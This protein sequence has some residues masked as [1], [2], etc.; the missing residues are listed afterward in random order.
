METSMKARLEKALG[1]VKDLLDGLTGEFMKANTKMTKKMA[2]VYIPLQLAANTKARGKT[3]KWMEREDG[4]HPKIKTI[5]EAGKMG[6]CTDVAHTL[7]ITVLSSEIDK[8]VKNM[9]MACGLGRTEQHTL[10][11]G[12]TIRTIR[13]EEFIL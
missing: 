13:R 11:N 4:L 12:W 2:K 10:R 6:K 3:I 7:R 5:L 1:M 8:M 9:V